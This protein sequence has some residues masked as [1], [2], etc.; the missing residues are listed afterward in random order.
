MADGINPA[1]V[2]GFPASPQGQSAA[3]PGSPPTG[4]SPAT[5]PVAA[6]GEQAA[7]LARLAIAVHILEEALPMLGMGDEAGRAVHSALPKLAKFVPAG[8]VSPGIEN[9]ELQKLMLKNRQN[10]MSVM[11]MRTPR[12][13]MPGAPPTPTPAPP[14][15]G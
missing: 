10:A 5:M 14:M 9:A 3:P 15:A 13:A 8:A 1:G 6:R 11:Q 12:P 7:G 2:G 4:P